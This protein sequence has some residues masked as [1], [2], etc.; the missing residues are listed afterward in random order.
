MPRYGSNWDERRQQTSDYQ[1]DQGRWRGEQ[2][3]MRGQEESWREN[4][5]EQFG[6]G[7]E[8]W[9]QR[10]G[11]GEWRGSENDERRFGSSQ[12]QF[13]GGERDRGGF[14]GSRFG[15]HGSSGYGS[16]GQSGY[17]QGGFGNYGQ[18]SFGQGSYGQSGFGQSGFGQG[19]YE[20]GYG[21]YGQDFERGGQYQGRGSFE[22]D[23]RGP[24]Q[25]LGDKFREMTGRPGRGPKG[26]KRSDD[27][28]SDD[29]CER[30]ARSGV[31]SENVEVLVKSGE[32]TLSGTVRNRQDKWRL[33]ELVEDCFGVQDVHN[34]LRVERESQQGIRS[35][36]QG[37]ET[38]Q[39]S[40]R[41]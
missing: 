13:W 7:R 22:R 29:V 37:T 18:G 6:Q 20:S 41:H 34:N 9:R 24:F 10:S 39:P 8:D 14:G 3:D 15:E 12:G 27:R 36:Q 5:G 11:Q 19:G 31:E 33:E 1:P 38:K 23:E 21:R 28:I 26:Y 25:R 30:I 16:S 35:G 40:V 32:V 17:G 2:Q 4:R